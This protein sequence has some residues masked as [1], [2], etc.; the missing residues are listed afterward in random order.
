CQS[1]TV[2][3][4]V[5]SQSSPTCSNPYFLIGVP[6]CT[7]VDKILFTMS[8]KAENTGTASISLTSVDVIGE[9]ASLGSASISGNYTI[10]AVPASVYTPELT[11][12]PTPEPT[13][14]EVETPSTP[15]TPTLISP[16][17]ETIE[18]TIETTGG[19]E[20]IV[21]PQSEQQSEERSSFLAGIGSI[22]TFGTN[23]IWIYI[24]FG[25]IILAGL[26]YLSRKFK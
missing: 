8:V 17:E 5:M 26:I 10:N 16:E 20:E 23:S 12:M 19:E 1:I 22:I 15:R 3:G 2:A 24:L 11:P 9:G 21:T 25:I 7:T 6:S 13:P 14:E 18:E 4:D